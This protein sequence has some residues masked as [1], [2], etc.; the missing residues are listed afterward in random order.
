[1][2]N[3]KKQIVIATSVLVLVTLL[4]LGLTYAYYK[5]RVVGNTS[6]KSI[7][8]TMADLEL[9]Y[10]DNSAE[11]LGENAVPIPSDTEIGSKVFTVNNKGLDISFV[12]VIDNVSITKNQVAT[13]FESNDF[14]Y[15]LTCKR[16][17]G[18]ACVGVT[19]QSVFPINGGILVGDSIKANDVYT[20][21]LKL[22]YIDTGE[23]QSADMGKSLQARIN[24]TD[25]KE[26][27][28]PYSNNKNSLAYN[29]IENS[30]IRINGTELLSGPLTQVAER[31]N[32]KDEKL[33]TIT[34]DDYGNSYYYRG[35]VTDNY[36][37]FAG[38]CWKAVRISGD[39]SIKLI[40]EDQDNT[41][42]TSDGNW[43]I[44][45]ETGGSTN[46]GNFGY[47]QSGSI[48]TVNYLN[49]QTNSNTSMANAFKNFQSALDTKIIDNYASKT[50]T[51]Y[52]KVGDWCLNQVAYETTKSTETLTEVEAEVKKSNGT[53]IYY[54][55]RMR[56]TESNP[57]KPTLK[58]LGVN[59]NKFSDGTDM[60]VG[61]ITADEMVYAGDVIGSGN[62]NYYL[63][64]DYQKAKYMYFW[65]LTPSY[66][67]GTND[68]AFHVRYDGATLS[69]HVNDG[70][71]TSF[72][73]AINLLAG[74]EITGGDGTKTNP[75][76]IK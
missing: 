21:T 37:D 28:N 72:R 11:I 74:M 38:M 56:L 49:G 32:L 45:T 13:T 65:T 61:T 54:D 12:V 73:P 53:P 57:K 3:N 71:V 16:K 50:L 31:N 66:F 14:R 40:L 36:V 46:I 62:S 8:V 20:Y 2:K 33:L 42:A 5:T 41:C 7:S 55:S 47:V 70:D 52:L 67:N 51:E 64:N 69:N 59:M 29:I 39:G 58:C 27:E 30:K 15:T 18:T 75:Y 9:T 68:R 44:P 26:V 23:D 19:T 76:I 34:A 17:D 63:I 25:A 48:Y 4:L 35:N 43:N 24:I 10:E 6:D 60:Y 22:W 1:M